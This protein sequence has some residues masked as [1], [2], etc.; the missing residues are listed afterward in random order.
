MFPSE[1]V[2]KLT[3]L[4]FLTQCRQTSF[5][6]GEVKGERQKKEKNELQATIKT[7]LTTTVISQTLPHIH[8]CQNFRNNGRPLCEIL[9]YPKLLSF[10]MRPQLWS[11]IV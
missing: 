1:L 7:N 8:S 2:D 9:S 10:Y 6:D 3:S 5:K 11:L 4:N